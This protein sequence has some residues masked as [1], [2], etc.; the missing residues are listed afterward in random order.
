VHLATH[1]QFSSNLE[2]TF[3]LTWSDRISINQLNNLLRGA[4]VN[5]QR[6]IELLVMSACQTAAGD[7]RAALGLAGMAVQA[8]ARSTLASLWSVDD[9]A[10]SELMVRFYQE[11]AKGNV[12]KAESLRQAELAMLHH[13]ESYLQRPFYWAAFVLL[14]NWR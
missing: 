3:I 4:D 9:Q 13:P 6:P 11:L 7:Q 10:T 14:G 1:G 2:D 8:G 5:R 12:T